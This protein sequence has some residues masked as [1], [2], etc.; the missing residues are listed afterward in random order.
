MC[1]GDDEKAEDKWKG[2]TNTAL[3]FLQMHISKRIMEEFLLNRAYSYV[4]MMEMKK[5]VEK[6]VSIIFIL[7]SLSFSQ[8]GLSRRT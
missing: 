2:K 8:S 7:P 1:A 6:S 4:I 3:F 5:T